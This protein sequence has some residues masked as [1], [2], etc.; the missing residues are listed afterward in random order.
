MMPENINPDFDNR[1]RVIQPQTQIFR[2][3]F[4][5]PISSEQ[6]NLFTNSVVEDLDYLHAEFD[7][8]HDDFTAKLKD[9]YQNGGIE[10]SVDII[11]KTLHDY[12]AELQYIRE[13]IENLK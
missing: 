11:L 6:L 1:S 2:S 8:V 5:A 10:V 12:A 4:R 9:L 13:E 7:A 3:S